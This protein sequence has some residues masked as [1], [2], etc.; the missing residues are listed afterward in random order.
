V[1]ILGQLL[2]THSAPSDLLQS[3]VEVTSVNGTLRTLGRSKNH[4]CSIVEHGPAR[5]AWERFSGTVEKRSLFQD[6]GRVVDCF[7]EH[8]FCPYREITATRLKEYGRI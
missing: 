1:L 4:P 2:S 6:K 5:K 3:V 8:I 7:N